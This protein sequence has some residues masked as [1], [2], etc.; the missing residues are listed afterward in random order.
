MKCEEEESLDRWPWADVDSL[1][2]RICGQCGHLLMRL[3]CVNATSYDQAD[4]RREA[5]C[6]VCSVFAD[7]YHFKK[8]VFWA[9]YSFQC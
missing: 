2:G 1:S 4:T 5:A 7:F 9:A 8:I 6:T 3:H